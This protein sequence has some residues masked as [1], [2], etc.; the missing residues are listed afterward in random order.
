MSM[1]MI[2]KS[3]GR[4]YIVYLFSYNKITVVSVELCALL[5]LAVGGLPITT[6]MT[7]LENFHS[8]QKINEIL[9]IPRFLHDQCDISMTFNYI[10]LG[11]KVSSFLAMKCR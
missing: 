2:S 4:K 3:N 7:F 10:T 9:F 6:L 5:S 11:L 8:H 1:I